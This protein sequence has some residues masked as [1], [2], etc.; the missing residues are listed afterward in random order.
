MYY[1]KSKDK[2]YACECKV[3]KEFLKKIEIKKLQNTLC[4]SKRSKYRS[5]FRKDPIVPTPLTDP[6]PLNLDILKSQ[7]NVD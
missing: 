3:K 4:P 6:T 2:I 7:K 1:S 5:I